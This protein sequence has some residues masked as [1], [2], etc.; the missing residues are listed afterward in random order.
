MVLL[1]E[2][3]ALHLS[4]RP[5]PALSDFVDCFWLVADAQAPRKERILPSGTL[6][7]V[8]NLRAN[9]V[10]IYEPMKLERY[11]KFSGAVM[12]GT[13]SSAFACDAMQHESMLSVHFK[14]GGAF[15]FLGAQANELAE[16]HA[17]LTDL[18]GRSALDMFGVEGTGAAVRDAV[19]EVGVCQRHFIQLFRAEVGLTPKLFSDYCDF[20]RLARSRNKSKRVELI[21]RI[22]QKHSCF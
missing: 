10:R 15:P 14:P 21:E 7:L 17:D 20:K 5:G 22:R 13:Y 11:R 16:T 18:W 12:S 19:R 3:C 8:I 2:Y 4:Y 6:E 1:R 9:E